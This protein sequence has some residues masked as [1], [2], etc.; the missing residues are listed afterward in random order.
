[1]DFRWN[2]VSTVV[3][4]KFVFSEANM[5]DF[6]KIYG[7]P[8][9]VLVLS[10][11]L[12]TVEIAEG[13]IEAQRGLKY[14]DITLGDGKRAVP[15]KTAIIHFKAWINDNGK[16]GA[17]LFDSYEENF[18]ISFKIGTKRIT[19][20]LN[21][22]VNGMRVGGKRR[23]FIPPELNPKMASDEFP[24]K[25]NLIFEVELIELK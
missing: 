23:L 6:M 7:I 19:D 22:G 9:M 21:L 12:A 17:K 11:A 18:P 24:A 15:G 8:F 16:K 4:N 5:E 25:A 10:V 3:E 13:L 1:M 20:G 14:E 2:D